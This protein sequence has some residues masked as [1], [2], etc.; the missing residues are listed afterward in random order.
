MCHK[1]YRE[2]QT[3][4]SSIV[5]NVTNISLYDAEIAAH[6]SIIGTRRL[7][8]ASLRQNDGVMFY[9]QVNRTPHPC[10]PVETNTKQNPTGLE[11]ESLDTPVWR[12]AASV[13]T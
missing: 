7:A 11:A 6:S 9:H 10:S 4:M 1:E 12:T 8:S 3:P 2:T 5:A 13:A